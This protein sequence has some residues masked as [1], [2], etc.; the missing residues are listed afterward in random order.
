[1]NIQDVARIRGL[2]TDMDGVWFVGDTPLPGAAAAL[3]RLRERAIPVRFVTNTTTKT[4]AQL[5]R[6]MGTM[7][8]DVP[9]AEFVTT[10]VATARHL[11]AAGVRAIFPV[12][13]DS[14]RP[15]FAG[16]EESD[17]PEAIV[18]GDIGNAW[19]YDLMNRLFRMAM[20][21]ARLVAMHRGRFWQVDDGLRMDIGAFV[22]GLEYATGQT[23]TVIGK[24]SRTMFD[25]ALADI[26]LAAEDVVM[27]GD[28]VQMD[29]GG[30]QA[31]GLRGVLVKTGKYRGDLVAASGITPDLV[32]D[33]I[34]ALLE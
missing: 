6:K 2:L 18:I 9:A 20:D 34:A 27:V 32:L 19:N 29:I 17:Q 26:G 1:M 3:A 22:A 25:A 14:I 7:G 8:L 30:A 28:D 23:A 4:A 33:S 15:E 21:G 13:A 11:R 31:A 10:P 16:F 24:P 5:A 12:V